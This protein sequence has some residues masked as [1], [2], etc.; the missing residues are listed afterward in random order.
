MRLRRG[1]II[2]IMVLVVGVVS[3][4]DLNREALRYEHV[5]LE[6]RVESATLKVQ[7]AQTQLQLVQLLLRD[8]TS[9]LAARHAEQQ[10]FEIKTRAALGWGEQDDVD[11]ETMTSTTNTKDR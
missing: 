4:Q 3:A 1:L 10:A 11:W 7:L 5:A 6:A 9:D 2:G 8:A